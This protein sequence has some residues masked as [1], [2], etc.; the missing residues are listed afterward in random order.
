M[1]SGKRGRPEW[2][3]L[4]ILLIALTSCDSGKSESFAIGLSRLDALLAVK[5]SANLAGAFDRLYRNARTSDDWVSIAKRSLPA[6][7]AGDAGRCA[8]TADRAIHAFKANETVAAVAAWL[9]LRDGR[10]AD[11]LG[12]FD[13]GLDR[14][15]HTE[16][17]AEARLGLIVTKP[18]VDQAE[19]SLLAKA[20]G[21]ASWYYSAA[22]LALRNSD[23]FAAQ[24]WLKLSLQGGF[25]P[26]LTVLWDAGMDAELLGS[27]SADSSPGD[28][29]L[30]ADAAW[31]AGDRNRAIG[32]WRSSSA[33]SSSSWQTEAALASLAAS[34]SARMAAASDLVTRHGSSADALRFA[35]ALFLGEGSIE[36]AQ[37][38]T[39][40]LLKSGVALPE[41]LGLEIEARGEPE[42]WFAAQ[43]TRLA[44]KY[45]EVPAAREFALRVLL[46]HGLWDEYLVV[47]DGASAKDRADSG[48]W[49]WD[50]SAAVLRGEFE[51][52]A[53]LAAA[54]AA[55]PDAAQGAAGAFAE[56]MAA[57][58]RG[59]AA[60][61]EDSF[62]A[63]LT[64][65]AD[66]RERAASLK[67]LGR[68]EKAAGHT[69]AAAAAWAEAVQA[70]PGDA[71]AKVLA[72]S[73]GN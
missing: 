12:L 17:W 14:M 45:P 53:S 28:L 31:I 1:G 23:R 29:A 27:L 7:A 61:A 6:E 11:A 71:E 16:L 54:H 72:A 32:L 64:L 56:G 46:A 58:L 36:E 30:A 34:D 5:A 26:D 3:A 18:V 57:S 55:S 49:F 33:R 8:K 19:C 9:Y 40:R 42:G 52:A 65:A 51:D 41:A 13:S 73:I 15:V 63:A 35:A 21:D 10:P 38:L 22:L 47:H 2:I 39:P 20:T 70:D 67:E 60:T 4:A 25:Q 37:G 68:L 44:E 43:A 62:R 24:E 69:A 48:W 59:D 66:G 50:F